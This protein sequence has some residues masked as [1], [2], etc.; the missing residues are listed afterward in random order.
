MVPA[1]PLPPKHGYRGVAGER[2][3]QFIMVHL[4][5]LHMLIIFEGQEKEVV[6][7]TSYGTE[8]AGRDLE[9]YRGG[10][11]ERKE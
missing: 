9:E 2:L 4:G 10:F 7:Q 8:G 11:R 1:W 5:F 6:A 3:H